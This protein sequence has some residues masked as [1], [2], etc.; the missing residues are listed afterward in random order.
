MVQYL[1]KL[2]MIKKCLY[3]SRIRSRYSDLRLRGARA[4][5]NISCSPTIKL[6]HKVYLL[7]SK[8]DW[9]A[10]WRGSFQLSRSYHPAFPGSGS[11]FRI[12]IHTESGFETPVSGINSVCESIYLRLFNKHHSFDPWYPLS[13]KVPVSCSALYSYSVLRIRDVYPRSGFFH[14]RSRAKGTGSRI[15]IRNKEFAFVKPKKLLLS[16]RKYA[17]GC[18]SQIRILFNPGSRSRGSATLFIILYSV[19]VYYCLWG[20]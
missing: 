16:S 1:K 8:K 7:L 12:R 10:S 6:S 14:P 19:F 3:R 5:R 17:Q 18:L 4:E 15:R 2:S 9:E 13:M 20:L 11:F